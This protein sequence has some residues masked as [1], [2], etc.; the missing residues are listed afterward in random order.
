VYSSYRESGLP[1]A[2]VRVDKALEMLHNWHDNLPHSL[3]LPDPLTLLPADLFTRASGY[4]QGPAAMLSE[5]DKFGQDRACWALHMSYYQVR[6]EE[7][8]RQ[9]EEGD[10]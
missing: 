8:T 7:S 9:W 4:Q 10:C 6:L 1:H 2:T 5:A 3:R